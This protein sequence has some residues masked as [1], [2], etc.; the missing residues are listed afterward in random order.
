M[1]PSHI[2]NPRIAIPLGRI[3]LVFSLAICTSAGAQF[4]KPGRIVVGGPP[5]SSQDLLAR[6]FAEKF[7]EAAGRHYIVENRPGAGSTIAVDTVARSAPDG[8]TLL[9]S[10]IGPLL[11]EPVFNPKLPYD[12]FRDFTPIAQISTSYVVYAIAQKVPVKS[13]AE[14][15][16]AVRADSN[17]GFY[18][19]AGTNG[20][21]YLFSVL[22]QRAA[23]I[24]MTNVPYKSALDAVKAVASGEVPAGVL[25]MGEAM[26]IYRRGQLRIVAISGAR[27]STLLPEIPTFRELGY[28]DLEAETWYAL[29]G[30]AKLPPALAE[31]L[32][33]AATTT[34]QQKEVRDMLSGMGLEPTGTSPREL[35]EIMRRDAER[36]TSAVK[37]RGLKRE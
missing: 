2:A 23:G 18:S 33:K 9:I 35:A 19:T 15:F 6:L 26:P 36:W 21:P 24:T 3:L 13:L 37:A 31:S 14:F 32:S 25:P 28:K 22:L 20:I 4:D 17:L 30:P 16:P 29:L 7:R 34:V 27:R 8:S 10:P 11:I 5:G 1:M 12:T